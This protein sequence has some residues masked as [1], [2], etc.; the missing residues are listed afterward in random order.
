[1]AGLISGNLK[2][3]AKKRELIIFLICFLTAYA[4]NV[5]GIIKSRSPAGELFTNLHVV[6]LVALAFYLAV[7]VLR[8]L[9][10]LVSRFWI[11]K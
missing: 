6:L 9:Y 3:N 7:A 1:M 10:Y 4:M 11:R 5:I 2:K 8:V